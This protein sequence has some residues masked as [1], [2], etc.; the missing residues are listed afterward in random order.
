MSPIK[1]LILAPLA[2]VASEVWRG[3]KPAIGPGHSEECP[4]ASLIKRR[5]ARIREAAKILA[6]VMRLSEPGC[7]TRVRI[8]DRKIY[9]IPFQRI[10]FVKMVS[11]DS[12]RDRNAKNTRR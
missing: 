2:T 1:G 9:H 6:A 3:S 7:Y 8:P 4:P 12:W 10:H 11:T 5:P